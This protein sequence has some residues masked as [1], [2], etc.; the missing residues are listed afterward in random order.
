MN[1]SQADPRAD[2]SHPNAASLKESG[3]SDAELLCR[4]RLG[5]SA[6]VQALYQRY[7]PAVWRFA[8][9]QVR[10]DVHAAEDVTAETFLAAVRGLGGLDPERVLLAGWLMGIARHKLADR[11]REA[12][13]SERLR[14]EL[15][16]GEVESTPAGSAAIE[17]EETRAEVG[18]IMAGLAD[19]ERLVLEWK[20]LEAL[21]VC[22][23]A[24]RLGRTEKAVESLLYRARQAFRDQWSKTHSKNEGGDL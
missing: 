13:R 23:I 21:P 6:A 1:V 14:I 5:E 4:A 11:R 18:R 16:N 22:V 10:G 9:A 15:R 7:L 3:L 8:F 17:V 2:R 20:Y 12:E 24:S 19:E